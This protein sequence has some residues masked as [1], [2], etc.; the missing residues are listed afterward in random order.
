M[1]SASSWAFL[2]ASFPQP[3][4]LGRPD[5]DHLDLAVLGDLTDDGRDFLGADVQPDD[6]AVLGH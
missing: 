4:G 1:S 6:V 2:I 5:A 3:L